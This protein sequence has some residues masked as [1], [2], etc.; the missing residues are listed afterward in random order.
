MLTTIFKSGLDLLYYSGASQALRGI[1]GGIGA[2]FMLHH[3]R[4]GN[5]HAGSFAPN[6]GLEVTPQFLDGVI[7]H[8]R[9]QLVITQPD[10]APDRM[11]ETWSMDESGRLII[12]VINY[13]LANPNKVA[14]YRKVS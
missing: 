5:G 12:T 2:I 6:H 9:D 13:R 4:P 14:V 10:V 7:R 3:I 11:S 1:Y 8:V